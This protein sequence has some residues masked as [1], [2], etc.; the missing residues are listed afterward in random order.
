MQNIS[1]QIGTPLS[2]NLKIEASHASTFPLNQPVQ[3]QLLHS[4]CHESPGLHSARGFKTARFLKAFGG[5][6]LRV[7]NHPIPFAAQRH[8]LQSLKID[9]KELLS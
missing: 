9:D 5:Q 7:Q 2:E 6:A 3:K 1:V 8:R 4:D